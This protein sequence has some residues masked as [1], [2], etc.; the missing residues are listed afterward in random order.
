MKKIAILSFLLFTCF[1]FSQHPDIKPYVDHLKKVEKK[2]AKDYILQ[3]FENHDIVI[4]CERD[5]R[6]LS[7]YELIK[8][9]LSDAYFKKNVKNLFTEIGVINLQPEITAF[10][11]TKGLDSLYVEH[12]LAEFQFNSS[13]WSLWEKYN[14]QYLLRTIYD[15]NNPSADQINYYPSDV[16][17]DWSQ[18]LNSDDYRREMETET[19]PRDSLMAYNIIRQYEKFT[20]ESNTKALIIL[21]YRHAFKIHTLGAG[22]LMKN[23]TKYLF[24][25]FGDRATNI[26]ISQ[27]NFSEKDNE[28]EYTLIQNGKWDASF[29]YLNIDDVGFD[30]GGTA[31]GKDNLDIWNVDATHTYEETFDGFVF[32]KPIEAYQLV[33]Y[34]DGL[35]PKEMEEEFFRRF[36]I[37]LEYQNN[38]ALLEK[39]NTTDFRERILKEVNTRREDKYPNLAQLITDRDNYLKE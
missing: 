9:V 18:V 19:E 17:F 11:K 3:K 36:K 26:M 25:Y 32:Y 12:K 1:T 20:S 34:F 6:D 7:Q 4:L 21:N 37:Q 22:G 10:L 24:D 13:F 5:H 38:T 27:A 28:F 15:I 16:E 35:I 14:Y 30:L 31:F 29:K 23:T 2:S 33:S 39:L 8:D